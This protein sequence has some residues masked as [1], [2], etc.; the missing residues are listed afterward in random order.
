MKLVLPLS[1]EQHSKLEDVVMLPRDRIESNYIW[2]LAI[3]LE[4]RNECCSDIQK[5][6]QHMM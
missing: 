2:N 1:S 4:R 3:V 5:Y 6:P